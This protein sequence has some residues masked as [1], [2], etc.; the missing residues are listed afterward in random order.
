MHFNVFHDSVYLLYA[1]FSVVV[2]LSVLNTDQ[3]RNIQQKN[4][5]QEHK[6]VEK[7]HKML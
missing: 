7:Q 2:C 6:I 1:F 5:M 3:Q 4:Y